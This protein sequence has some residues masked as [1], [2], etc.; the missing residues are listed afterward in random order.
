MDTA[1]IIGVVVAIVIVI[2]LL[3]LVVF[4]IV[5]VYMKRRDTSESKERQGKERY[6]RNSVIVAMCSP[7][8]I[9]P[10]CSVVLT[11]PS[12]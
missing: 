12:D 4:V 11:V 2:L 8:Y 3:I 5:L 10:G 1:V 7:A 9:Q 6:E